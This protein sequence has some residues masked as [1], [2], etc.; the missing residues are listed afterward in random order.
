ME[1][2]NIEHKYMLKLANRTA[3]FDFMAFS[4]KQG[5]SSASAHI[6]ELIAKTMA[7]AK[8]LDAEK[9]RQLETNES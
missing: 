5:F 4:K 7:V 1:K 3:W 9:E 8:A 2:K 6:E